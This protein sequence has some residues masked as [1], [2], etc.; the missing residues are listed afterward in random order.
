MSDPISGPNRGPLHI[1]PRDAGAPARTN[2]TAG[3]RILTDPRQPLNPSARLAAQRAHALNAI[4]QRDGM[5]RPATRNVDPADALKRAL[6]ASLRHAAHARADPPQESVAVD[7][8]QS[9]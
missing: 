1:P 5:P 3:R 6:A 8:T 7:R 4:V 9:E 2:Q